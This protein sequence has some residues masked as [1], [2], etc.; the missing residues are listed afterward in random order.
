MADALQRLIREALDRGSEL[1]WGRL[2]SFS[3]WGLGYPDESGGRDKFRF[4]RYFKVTPRM[5]HGVRGEYGA[6]KK[7][8]IDKICRG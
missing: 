5:R 2:L 1:A 7:K 8:S 6:L 4:Q 3:Y